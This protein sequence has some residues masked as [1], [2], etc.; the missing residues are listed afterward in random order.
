MKASR[1]LP[2]GERLSRPG[3]PGSSAA[4]P[5]L[6]ALEEE[7]EKSGGSGF[8]ALPGTV[9][10]ARDSPQD[11]SRLAPRLAA[12]TVARCDA[13]LAPGHPVPTP[14]RPGHWILMSP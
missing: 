6:L 10:K 11:H 12:T 2:E 4:L 9:P 5:K 3:S 1:W 14:P 13:V 7:R 8:S